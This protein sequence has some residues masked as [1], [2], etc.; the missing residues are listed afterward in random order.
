MI[1]AHQRTSATLMRAVADTGIM[2]PDPGLNGDQSA[3]LAA[4]QSQRGSAFDKT[5]IR[6]QV[7]A[8][9]SALVVEQGYATT[10]DNPA[11]RQYAASSVSIIT[12]HLQM[13]E[14]IES[15]QRAD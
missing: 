6:Q 13:A 15:A 10:G 4:L 2:P 5:Y 3:L 9:R 1:K 11:I 14:Q 8:H 12:A 7:L